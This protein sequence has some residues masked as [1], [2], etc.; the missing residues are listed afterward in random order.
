MIRS[1]LGV[2]SREPISLKKQLLI[3]VRFSPHFTFHNKT[4]ASAFVEVLFVGLFILRMH[5]AG[6]LISLRAIL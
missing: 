6:I 1:V 3:N 2:V 5:A 4:V